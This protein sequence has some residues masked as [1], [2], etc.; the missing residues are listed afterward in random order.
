M[1]LT[2][3]ILA[4]GQ[5]TRMK[6]ALPKVLHSL[7]GRPLVEYAVETATAV[8]GTTPVLVVGHGSE[9]VRQTLGDR[10]RYVLQAQQ[11]G[12]AHAVLQ[13]RDLLWGQA[14]AVLVSYA[15]MP[16][17]T[18]ATLRAIVAA[19]G[20][21]GA[22]MSFLTV[23][24]R[25]PRGFGRVVRNA[26]GEPL[27]VVEE[28]SCTPEQLQIRELNAGVYC[29][30]ADWLWDNLPKIPL[31]PKG[32]YYL[33]DTVA[34]AVSQGRRAVAVQTT[35]ERELI[36][37]N[38][39][40]HLAEAE[41]ILRERINRRWME[42][43]VTMLDPATTYIEPSVEIGRDTVLLPGVYLRGRT[44][45]GAGCRI[46]PHTVIADSRIGDDCRVTM[47]VIEGAEVGE[48]ATVGPFEHL[49]GR[50]RS[51]VARPEQGK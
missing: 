47:A 25:D 27:A 43:G 1:R 32:E 20:A 8:T 18:E 51:V 46:G 34:L 35:D 4:A 10:A 6:S 38:N 37:I 16:L 12:T 42:A 14:D 3:V 45:I 19:Y 28:A 36:G 49:D 33:T 50:S 5:G 48:G 29:F 40:V 26:A 21:G 22:A 2:A 9:L 23:I 17:L 7:A 15:D 11:L 31:S 39:R 30:N 13:A 44:R 24:A 41:Q